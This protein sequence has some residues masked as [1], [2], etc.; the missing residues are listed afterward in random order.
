MYT[1]LGFGGWVFRGL[2]IVIW[3]DHM[4]ENPEGAMSQ[5]CRSQRFFKE[6]VC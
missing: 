1:G 6:T 3:A 5:L 4:L 2:V